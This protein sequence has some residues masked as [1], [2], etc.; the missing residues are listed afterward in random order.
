MRITMIGKNGARSLLGVAQS[1][2]LQKAQSGLNFIGQNPKRED[3][4]RMSAEARGD[5]FG[6]VAKAN[7]VWID[8]ALS[9]L[10]AAWIKVLDGKVVEASQHTWTQPDDPALFKESGKWP[11][12]VPFVFVSET[13][14]LIEERK[15][16]AA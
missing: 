15:R 3:W 9:A 6:K 14:F 7:R 10:A 16:Q 5:F 13:L 12:K 8:A 4:Q 2:K 1:L 11:F